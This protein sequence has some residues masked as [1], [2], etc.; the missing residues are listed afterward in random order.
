MSP[1]HASCL[2]FKK[3]INHK[4]SIKI[5]FVLHHWISNNK[6]FETKSYL[7]FDKLVLFVFLIKIK[8]SIIAK[9]KQI[10]YQNNQ[11]QLSK[12]DPIIAR[13][14]LYVIPNEKNVVWEQIRTRVGT[15]YYYRQ[16]RYYYSQ[17]NLLL[18]L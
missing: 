1:L 17:N 6:N 12:Q 5:K 2:K 7:Y 18:S 3:S 11:E 4:S 15:C 8:C 14:S 13:T 10:K 9:T 16:K